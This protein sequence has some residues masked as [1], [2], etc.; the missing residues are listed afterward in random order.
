MMA[1]GA[2]MCSAGPDGVSHPDHQPYLE[3]EGDEEQ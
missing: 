1:T 3:P 2:H